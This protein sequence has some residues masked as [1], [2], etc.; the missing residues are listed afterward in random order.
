[1]TEINEYVNERDEELIVN[2]LRIELNVRLALLVVELVD[3]DVRDVRVVLVEADGAA[4][5]AY[6]LELL[7]HEAVDI[8]RINLQQQQ[9][10]HL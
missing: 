1:M 10:T 6:A 9:H 3:D 7:A 8:L 5:V 4:R 2:I